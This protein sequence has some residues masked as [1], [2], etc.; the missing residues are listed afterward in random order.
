MK[1]TEKQFAYLINVFTAVCANGMPATTKTMYTLDKTGD[2][3]DQA[4]ITFKY[5]D[6]AI[7]SR[8]IQLC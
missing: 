2:M 8:I 6:F 5:P 7:C 1:R 4:V 3:D